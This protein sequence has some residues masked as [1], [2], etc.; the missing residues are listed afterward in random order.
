MIVRQNQQKDLTC[1][2]DSYGSLFALGPIHTVNFRIE[3]KKILL[4]SQS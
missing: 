2:L 3:V 1:L 4:M